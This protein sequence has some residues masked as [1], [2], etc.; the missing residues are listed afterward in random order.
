MT[1]TPGDPLAELTALT[2]VEEVLITT[3]SPII[4]RVYRLNG[5]GGGGA[6]RG[7]GGHYVANVSQDLGDLQ[8]SPSF[9]ARPPTCQC[10]SC[11]ARRGHEDGT[12]TDF[13][14]REDT[15]CLQQSTL[16]CVAISRYGSTI[17]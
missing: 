7:Y 3:A 15:G 17:V 12:H 5:G 2:Q 9:L 4:M 13:L 6:Q 1:W 11:T 10:S 14:A 16:W 8:Y